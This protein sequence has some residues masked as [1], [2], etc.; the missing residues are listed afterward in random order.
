MNQL[1]DRDLQKQFGRSVPKPRKQIS[2]KE[3]RRKII[4]NYRGQT[5][6]AMTKRDRN[7]AAWLG[8]TDAELQE[9]K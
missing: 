5:L 8:I 7:K 4:L 6:D 1:T 9:G 2:R 3:L